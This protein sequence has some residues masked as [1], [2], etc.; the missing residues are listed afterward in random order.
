[1]DNAQIPELNSRMERNVEIKA[2][3]PSVD[4]LLPV[5]AGL[6]DRGP[7]EIWQDDTFFSCQRG[8]L[9]LRAFSETDG[10]LIFY[11]R[12]DIAGPKESSYIISPTKSADTLRAALSL[13]YGEIGRVRKHRT[14]FLKGRTRIH[15]DRVEG[16]GY[17]LELEVV[18]EQGETVEAGAGLAHEL[19]VK[20]GISHEQLVQEAYI[21]LISKT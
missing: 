13:A 8:R 9:K 11:Q 5:A 3:I 1:M 14:L 2:R 17:F 19:L 18:L 20:L 15:L 6:A 10:E 16:L 7:V 4:L 12:P 21:D